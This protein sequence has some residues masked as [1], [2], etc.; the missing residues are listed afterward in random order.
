MTFTDEMEA[1]FGSDEALGITF[2]LV[3]PNTTLPDTVLSPAEF[4]KMYAELGLNIPECI[5]LFPDGSSAVCCTDYARQ[6]SKKLPGRVQIFGFANEDNPTSRV[7]IEELHPG[8]HDFAVVDG[9]YVVDPW[10]RLVL[11]ETGPIVFDMQDEQGAAEIA[12]TYGPQSCWESM[13]QSSQMFFN[14]PKG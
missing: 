1:L 8:G 7:A 12:R 10:I 11:G 5:S 13:D 6:I 9:R 3:H 14:R 4:Q 2:H